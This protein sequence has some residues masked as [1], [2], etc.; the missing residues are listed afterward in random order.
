MPRL[1]NPFQLE[2]TFDPFVDEYRV[3]ADKIMLGMC[4][5]LLLCCTALAAWTSS[6]Q[7][8]F[9]IGVPTTLLGAYLTYTLPGHLL[10]RLFMGCAFM[11]F[12]GLIIHMFRGD[13]EAHFSA[14]GLIGVLL[15]YRDWRVV[16]SA[17]VFIYLHHLLLGLAQTYGAAIYVFDTPSFWPVFGLHVAYFL[18]FVGMMGYLAIALRQEAYEN[19]LVIE[20]AQKIADGDFTHSVEI[21]EGVDVEGGLL[22]SVALMHSRIREILWMIPTPTLVLRPDDLTIVNVNAA[23]ISAFG[24]VH[25]QIEDLIG[26]RLDSLGCWVGDDDCLRIR[27]F[28]PNENLKLN[29]SIDAFAKEERLRE[30]EFR[31]IVY[32]AH[33]S[34]L[35]IVVADDVTMRDRVQRH[36]HNLAYQDGLTELPN[37]QALDELAE[38]LDDPGH[39]AGYGYALVDLD[40]FKPIN[41]TYGH[42]AGDAVLKAIAGRL[43]GLVR[44]ND[45]VARIG[46]DEFA[47][48]IAD[49]STPAAARQFGE[50]LSAI[51]QD[52]IEFDGRLL[53]VGASIGLALSNDIKGGFDYVMSAADQAMYSIKGSREIPFEVFNPRRHTRKTDLHYAAKL[54]R[55]IECGE[56]QAYYQPKIDMQTG[57]F[58]GFEALARWIHPDRGVVAPEYFLDD[59][60]SY[61]L[62]DQFSRAVLEAV[63]EQLAEWKSEGLQIPSIAINLAE[64]TLATESGLDDLLRRLARLPIARERI[65]LEITEDVFISRSSDAIRESLAKLHNAGFR[66]SLDDFGSG[67]ASLRHLTELPIDELKID[68]QFVAG[69]GRDHTAEVIIDGFLS[70]AEGLKA[71]VVAEGVE[72]ESQASFLKDGGCHHAQGFLFG[73]PL[74]AQEAQAYLRSLEVQKTSKVKTL[75]SV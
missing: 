8:L 2:A 32:Q 14:F 36:L 19:R 42:K 72:T 46:G 30:V 31:K 37:R 23:W 61:G 75:E 47:V 54:E 34:K 49:M 38:R 69:I 20:M 50:R 70:M 65:T 6:W 39:T 24:P 41:D 28:D 4:V 35:L 57:N 12:T 74:S 55:A 22:S 40:R 43:L 58:V 68:T 48:V 25:G 33:G 10:T 71:E 44:E 7:S 29:L 26:T 3:H 18:P 9:A 51:F 62:L 11:A 52:P 16:G 56:F 13:I 21:P 59:I 64:I 1:V 15:Y 67:Y 63:S 27:D 73:K 66:I 60:H 45:M 5:F 53:S 17:T